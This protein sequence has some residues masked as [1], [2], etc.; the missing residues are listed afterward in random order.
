[1][2]GIGDDRL[3]FPADEYAARLDRV[4]AAM[5]EHQLDA[6]ALVRPED[7]TWLTGL[8]HQG[9]FVFTMLLVPAD[10]ALTIVCRA[11]EQVTIATQTPE[12]VL[13]GYGD[14][15]DPSRVVADTLDWAGLGSAVIGI[16]R[17][18]QCL[19]SALW[20]E[21]VVGTPS[22]SWIDTSTLPS[23]EQRFRIGIVDWLRMVK[24]PNEIAMMRTA[25]GLTDRAIA[26]GLETA[27]VGVSERE[28][29]AAV[30]RE[31]VMGGSDQ[32]G[33]APLIRS[34]SRLLQE[35]TTWT[36]R[37]LEPGDPLVLELS[38]AACRYH[39][40]ATRMA[41][42]ANAPMGAGRARDV[43]VAALD[44]TVATLR[45]GVSSGDVYAAWQV[46]IDA[47]LGHDRLRRHH[48]GY[49]IGVGHAPSWV[50]SSTVLG[51]RREGRMPIDAGMTFHL[52]SWV[53]DPSIGT[54]L[55]SDTAVVTNS[56]AELLT[57][58]PRPLTVG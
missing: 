34:A 39:A 18:S 25:A 21:I 58:A 6:L 35:H 11:M 16:D 55:V 37:R 47:G 23:P 56:G 31:L 8:D 43:A 28:I 38:G 10:G 51:L 2:T 46:C 7:I 57:T 48:C 42:V 9:F 4:R 49:A 45:P 14:D 44:A 19:P 5:R 41:Y 17:S 27:G 54:S 52:L 50:G 26:A 40:P 29:A 24:S 32:P 22:V 20:D 3:A 53:I 30:Y 15:D 1:M 13:A 12:L 36:D 33:F